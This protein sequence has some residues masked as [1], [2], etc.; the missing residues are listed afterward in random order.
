MESV[1]YSFSDNVKN[2]GDPR[3]STILNSRA[4]TSC[5]SFSC[6]K[7]PNTVMYTILSFKILTQASAYG[8]DH[9]LRYSTQLRV[10][11]VVHQSIDTCTQRK[12][13]EKLGT[14]MQR[15]MYISHIAYVAM[16]SHTLTDESKSHY[17]NLS[18][19]EAKEERIATCSFQL[20]MGRASTSIPTTSP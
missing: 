4:C 15:H 10:R 9:F 3:M 7:D 8:W 5:F 6:W 19:T 16:S 12:K 14:K 17:T 1:K 11:E 20:F 18:Y 13:G 2:E